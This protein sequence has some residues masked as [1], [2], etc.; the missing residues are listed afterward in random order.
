[1]SEE[2][3]NEE[4]LEQPEMLPAKLEDG[5]PVISKESAEQFE[6]VMEEIQNSA[7][8]SVDEPA[9]ENVITNKKQNISTG[10]GTVSS[11]TA[12]A[13]GVIGTGRVIKSPKPP[14]PNSKPKA[15]KVAIHSTRNVT[16]GPVGKVYKGYNLVTPEQAE[17]WLTRDHTR[18]A[19]PEEVAK[20]FGK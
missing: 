19:T 20:E 8:I 13:N 10:D 5:E 1:M 12:V 14:A 16:W 3:N 11:I 7:K 6:A 18:T 2:I 17:M 15:E 4:V 9:T